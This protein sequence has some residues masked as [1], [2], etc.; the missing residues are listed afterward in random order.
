[1]MTIAAYL[2]YEQITPGGQMP[3]GLWVIAAAVIGICLGI[4]LGYLLGRR[5]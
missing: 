5:G 1:M 2:V 3:P 4:A